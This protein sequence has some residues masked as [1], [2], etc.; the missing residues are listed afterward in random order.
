MN[1]I[2]S[3]GLKLS[4]EEVKKFTKDDYIGRPHIAKALIE[5]G[6]VK[7]IEE[8]FEKFLERGKPAYVER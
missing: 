8:A 1:K 3:F 6:Y 5:K 4:I 7:S 2:N